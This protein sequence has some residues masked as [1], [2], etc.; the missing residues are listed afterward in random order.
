MAILC[1]EELAAEHSFRIELNWVSTLLCLQLPLVRSLKD[2]GIHWD[3]VH[4]QLER[5]QLWTVFCS[6]LVALSCF[7]FNSLHGLVNSIL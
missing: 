7:G 6:K 3:W 1:S 5:G 4:P 2:S